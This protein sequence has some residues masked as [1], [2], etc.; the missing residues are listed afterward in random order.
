M[1]EP[2]S[3]R[4]DD[5]VE[6]PRDRRIA[7]TILLVLVIVVVGSGIWL[8]NAMFNQRVIDNCL[9]QGRTNCAP[10]DAPAR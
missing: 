3:Q 9:A 5:Y 1:D 10:I 7:N 2:E 4:Q 6:T 8:A